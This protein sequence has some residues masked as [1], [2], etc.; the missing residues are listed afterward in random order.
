MEEIFFAKP[1][2]RVSWGVLEDLSSTS[3]GFG[4]VSG[5]TKRS[6]VHLKRLQGG[7]RRSQKDVNRVPGILGSV[8]EDPRGVSGDRRWLQGLQQV[9]CAQ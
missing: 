2:Q 7:S 5:G 9:S 8:P 4:G 1:L 6:Q 3:G